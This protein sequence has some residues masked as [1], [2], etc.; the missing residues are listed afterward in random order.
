MDAEITTRRDRPGASTS[1]T[2]GASSFAESSTESPG[3]SLVDE[4]EPE[5]APFSPSEAELM[6]YLKAYTTDLE[7]LTR[8]FVSRLATSC[9]LPDPWP[10]ANSGVT[11]SQV[12]CKIDETAKCQQELN[13]L[14]ESRLSS[15]DVHAKT[16][17]RMHDQLNDYKA[18][19]IRQAMRPLF[20]DVIFCYDFVAEELKRARCGAPAA[21]PQSAALVLEHVKQMIA[22]LLLKYELE[23][24]R[25]EGEHFDRRLQQCVQ[26]VSTSVE[27]DDKKIA[28]VGYVGFRS[29]ESIIRKEQVS[30]YKFER[31]H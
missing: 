27:A 20:L 12:A 28:G 15:D 9:R 23:P 2:G 29:G 30:V 1:L 13:R 11:L 7:E 18:N 21:E 5:I 24:Y 22:D 19:F 8:A 31:A 16:V 26:T 25:A 4:G 10:G 6:D 14:F 17:E 3:L